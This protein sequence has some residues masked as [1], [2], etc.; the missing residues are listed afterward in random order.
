VE[1]EQ[2]Q[3]EEEEGLNQK[4]QVEE[5]EEQ[6]LCLQHLNERFE[7]WLCTSPSDMLLMMASRNG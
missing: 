7:R 4:A 3:E 6:D 5:E 2:E 1:E